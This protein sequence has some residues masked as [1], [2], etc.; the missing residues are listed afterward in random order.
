M[1]D[2]IQI[3]RADTL[4]QFGEEIDSIEDELL[5]SC[6]SPIEKRFGVTLIRKYFLCVRHL[7]ELMPPRIPVIP[8]YD[9][10]CGVQAKHWHS[11]AD[12]FY[13]F[14]QAI[15]ADY[16]V[17]FCVFMLESKR[18]DSIESWRS[19]PIA[20]ECDGHDFHERTKGQAIRDRKRDRELQRLGFHVMRF[21]GAEIHHDA[22]KCCHEVYDAIVDDFARR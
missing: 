9:N 2:D 5:E 18:G 13:I 11:L 10:L 16:R 17:D 6:E 14:P 8:F 3:S 21:T 15:I 7:P 1:N 20:I 19:K 22:L 12:R 4:Q